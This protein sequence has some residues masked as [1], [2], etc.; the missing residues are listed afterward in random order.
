MDCFHK[1]TDLLPKMLNYNYCLLEILEQKQDNINK[2]FTYY[3]PDYWAK[4]NAF[5]WDC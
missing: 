2:V 1:I 3:K 5:L 4:I